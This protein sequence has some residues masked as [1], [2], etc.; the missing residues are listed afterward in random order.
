MANVASG[1]PA[2]AF[3]VWRAHSGLDGM[4]LSQALGRF[5]AAAERLEQRD[6][7]TGEASSEE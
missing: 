5:V 7:D 1:R 6:A 2:T 3:R 4:E